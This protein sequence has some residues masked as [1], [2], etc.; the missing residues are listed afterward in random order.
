[1]RNHLTLLLLSCTLF[2]ISGLF[3][4][5]QSSPESDLL[6]VDKD[7]ALLSEQTDPKTAFTAYLAPDAMLIGRRGDPIVGFDN[8]IASF[9]DGS[10]IDLLWQPQMAEVAKSGDMGWTWGTY[11]VV[12]EGKQISNG[13][14]VNIWIRQADGKWK[15]RVDMGNQEPAQKTPDK[16]S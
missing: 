2:S 6:Q 8:A 11:Q 16:D 12:A 15:V 5:E 9:D 13:K 4:G 14:Y 3:A 10:G 1:M 7:F